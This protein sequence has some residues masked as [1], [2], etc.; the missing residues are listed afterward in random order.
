MCGQEG[1]RGW[2]KG[3]RAAASSSHRAGRTLHNLCGGVVGR[4]GRGRYSCSTVFMPVT[5]QGISSHWPTS[6]LSPEVPTQVTPGR[7][8]FIHS[9]NCQHCF[10]LELTKMTCYYSLFRPSFQ[11]L[12]T[13]P[14]GELGWSLV[15]HRQFLTHAQNPGAETLP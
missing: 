15:I 9:R 13:P 4:G 2:R 6:F 11:A 1:A 10:L 7:P 8:G 5:Q 14:T 3:G 12:S